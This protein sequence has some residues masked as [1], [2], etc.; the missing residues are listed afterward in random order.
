MI[1]ALLLTAALLAADP[2]ALAATADDYPAAY[3]AAKVDGQ[4]LVV[5]IC[6]EGC[7]PCRRVE[8]ELLPDLRKLGHF[9]K[10][11]AERD[12]KLLSALPVSGLPTLLVYHP[13][14]TGWDREIAR[15]EDQIRDYVK[16]HGAAAGGDT[17]ASTET[18]AAPAAAPPAG[19]GLRSSALGLSSEDQG[20]KTQDQ[21]PKTEGIRGA[22]SSV[23][24]A[25]ANASA[26]IDQIRAKGIELSCSLFGLTLTIHLQ[27][28]Q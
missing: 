25:A 28:S 4:P 13:S 14:T 9:A 17:H 27:V 8:N 19:A 6:G 22:A 12:E 24:E 20:P 23:D 2:A 26:L 16:K 10:L 7:P 5:L 11:S 3:A 18:V 21:K 15:G 1:S